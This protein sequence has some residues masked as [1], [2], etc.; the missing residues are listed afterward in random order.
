LKPYIDRDDLA[1]RVRERSWRLKAVALK[2]TVA[3]TSLRPLLARVARLV[4]IDEIRALE[5]RPRARALDTPALEAY[6]ADVTE[7]DRRIDA[8]TL[9]SVLRDEIPGWAE[10]VVPALFAEEIDR[11]E[12]LR[13]F[14]LNREEHGLSPWSMETMR[15]WL[16]R[17]RARLRAAVADRQGSL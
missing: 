8:R 15:V 2:E 17:L 12:A 11:P 16:H 3:N 5:R 1:G 6:A 7:P 14:N 4:A 9:V 10:D 13:L